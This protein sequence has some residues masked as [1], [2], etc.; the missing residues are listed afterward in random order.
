[1]V[2]RIARALAGLLC[3]A[4]VMEAQQIEYDLEQIEAGKPPQMGNA[5]DEG[6][7]FYEA[8]R[9]VYFKRCY[10]C[11]GRYGEGDG[12]AAH[13]L[14][15]RPRDFTFGMFK[16]RTTLSGE[17]PT[18][19]DLFR[20]VSR[21]VP[22][23]AMPAWG[24]GTFVLPEIERWQ[25]IHFLKSLSEDFENEDLNPYEEDRILDVG[26]VP[27]TTAER[28]ENGK[29]WFLDADKA[30]CVKCHGPSG[31][32]NGEAAGSHSDDWGDLILPAD[33]TKPWRYKNGAAVEDIYRT[34][35]LGLNGTPMPS[36]MDAIPD[37]D[38]RWDLAMYVVSLLEPA[39][40]TDNVIDAEKIEGALPAT[41]DDPAWDAAVSYDV[42]TGG[43]VVLGP[44]WQNPSVD[45]VHM[46]ALYNDDEVALLLTW[47]D[48]FE[49]ATSASAPFDLNEPRNSST[50]LEYGDEVVT[51]NDR[52][53]E[54]DEIE[55][56]GDLWNPAD[57][58]LQVAAARIRATTAQLPDQLAIHFPVK[59]PPP[60]K[61]ERPYLFMGDP[62]HPVNG[63]VW[64]AGAEQAV[65][66]N[67]KGPQSSY[68]A[69]EG[70][71]GPTAT[72]VFE[73]GQW[74]LLLRRSL[75][76]D[77]KK[78]TH[79]AP[80]RPIP[81]TLRVWDGANGE[82][83]LQSA[84]SS[85]YYLNLKASTPSRAYVYGLLGLAIT[86]ALQLILVRRIRRG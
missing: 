45:M 8:G 49:N 21:G 2:G 65:D 24:E 9:Q 35:T 74:R 56:L 86:F 81:F 43:Q 12:M 38:D 76:G 25:A 22:G 54:W 18:D 69:Q 48:R 66:G 55:A 16:F 60:G 67:A 20:T 50:E 44:R 11:H 71:V 33:M 30:G 7:P 63:W 61:A 1:M 37:D 78:D 77:K 72:A 46:Q 15:P 10:S 70:E 41:V 5:P 19:A 23:T 85:W 84:M 79:F 3:L 28:I 6:D 68:T 36:F 31:R 42:I 14:D 58:Y 26:T 57:T 29:R 83:G 64:V 39:A 62:G 17:L 80:G 75:V 34:L 59:L 47:N 13:Y 32:G 82:A 4:T 53:Y 27:G 73:D 40:T 51:A 52:A